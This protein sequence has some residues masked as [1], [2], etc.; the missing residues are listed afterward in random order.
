LPTLGLRVHGYRVH[1][2]DNVEVDR[3]FF[4]ELRNKNNIGIRSTA[5]RKHSKILNMNSRV[6][7]ISRVFFL[8]TWRYLFYFVA[9]DSQGKDIKLTCLK[10]VAR[11]KS[12]KNLL[13]Q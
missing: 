9:L 6:I 5:C 7:F 4:K 1:G 13:F 10:L 11:T 12:N 3:F 2:Y 8:D